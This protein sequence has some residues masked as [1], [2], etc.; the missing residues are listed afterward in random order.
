MSVIAIGLKK[1][2]TQ[3]KFL[4]SGIVMREVLGALKP[5]DKVLQSRECSV[6]NGY[7]IVSETVYIIHNM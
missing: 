6:I 2:V 3:E 5:A 7:Q 4:F 1:L